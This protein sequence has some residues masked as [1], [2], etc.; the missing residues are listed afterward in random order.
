[1]S[2]TLVIL[3]LISSARDAVDDLLT[4]LVVHT[5]VDA[6]KRKRAREDHSQLHVWEESRAA[7]IALDAARHAVMQ[8][9][10]LRPCSLAREISDDLGAAQDALAQA[11]EQAMWMRYK[12]RA[13]R[14]CALEHS[15]EIIRALAAAQK[16]ARYLLA[17]EADP[18]RG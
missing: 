9:L 5:V 1:M 8:R 17:A 11:T 10:A 12:P 6:E 16:N 13:R 2:S 14:L 7:S 3:T 4:A 15:A 18:P